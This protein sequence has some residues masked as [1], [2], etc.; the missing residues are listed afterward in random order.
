MVLFNG[1]HRHYQHVADQL[2]LEHADHQEIAPS[3]QIVIVPIGSLNKSSLRALNFARSIAK[4]SVA[5]RIFYEPHEVEEFRKE[6]ARWGD[7]TPLIFLESPYRSFNEPLLAYIAELH[8]QDPDAYVTI[9]LP[10]FIPAHWWEHF[11]HNQTA[12]LFRKNTVVVDVP[13]HL[14][15]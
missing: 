3:R 13:Y 2:T 8:R 10:E 12:L 6:W 14:E 9:V 7:R 4:D 15:K 1:I 11:L 5:L